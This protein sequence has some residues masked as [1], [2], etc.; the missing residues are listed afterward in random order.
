MLELCGN[1]CTLLLL[2]FFIWDRLL[3]SLWNNLM[4]RDILVHVYVSI[5]MRLDRHDQLPEPWALTS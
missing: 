5:K 1:F 4:S 2:G 3:F